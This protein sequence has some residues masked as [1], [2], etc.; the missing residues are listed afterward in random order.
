[1]VKDGEVEAARRWLDWTR[2]EIG[3]ANDDRPYAEH[4]FVRFW[5]KGANDT[6]AATF[7]LAIAA[8]NASGPTEQAELAIPVLLQAR[9]NAA[10]EQQLN[11]DVALMSA[12]GRTENAEKLLEVSERLLAGRPDSD[13]ALGGATSALARLGRFDEA[14]ALIQKRLERDPRDPAGARAL[15]D[16]AGQKSDYEA[17]AKFLQQLVQRGEATAGDYN[18]LAWLSLFRRPFADASI[19]DARKAA[20][21]SENSNWPI[22]HTLAAVYAEAGKTLEARQTILR[23][24]DVAGTLDPRSED[25]YVFGRIAEEYGERDAAIAAYKRVEKPERNEAM[26][27]ST[28]LLAE[29]RLKAISAK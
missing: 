14:S 5:K 22:L 29:K 6:S 20:E 28:F 26:P 18:S 19:E 24:M 23:S 11:L 4:P 12:Y 9:Q 10:A 21:M 7:E 13:A 17:S 3:G 27:L 25:W 2:E 1:M 8:L 16:L 15:S